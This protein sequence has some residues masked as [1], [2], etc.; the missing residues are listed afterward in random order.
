MVLNIPAGAQGMLMHKGTYCVP[1]LSFVPSTS[2]ILRH[3]GTSDLGVSLYRVDVSDM[4][5]GGFL[6]RGIASL[7]QVRL[8]KSHN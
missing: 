7:R 8:V 4:N 3:D 5:V 1:L 2:R 6:S